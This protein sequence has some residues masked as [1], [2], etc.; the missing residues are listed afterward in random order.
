MNVVVPVQVANPRLD[1]RSNLFAASSSVFH[2]S[3]RSNSNCELFGKNLVIHL[4]SNRCVSGPFGSPFGTKSSVRGTR[5]SRIHMC[6]RWI[7]RSVLRFGS[8]SSSLVFR[9]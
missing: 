9:G 7:H 5:C 1:A 8:R 4:L 2:S 3:V 6:P